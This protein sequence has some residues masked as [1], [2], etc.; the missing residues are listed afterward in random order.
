MT[1]LS[2]L[3]QLGSLW[4]AMALAMGALWLLQRRSGNAGIVDVAWAG[5]LGVAGVF[6]A[7]TSEGEVTRRWL[8]AVLAGVW[9]F[10]LAIYLFFNRYLGRPED[11]RYRALREEWG[12]RA[13]ALLFWFFQLQAS[14]TVLFSLSFLVVTHNDAPA[15]FAWM[16]AAI[17][18]WIISI[19]G[20][21]IAD[22]QLARWRSRPENEGKT[23]RA[24]LWRYSRHP[25]YFF[26]W[27]YWW[28]YVFL[29]LGSGFTWLSVLVAFLMLVFLLK[30]TGIPYTEKCALK[31]REDYAEYQ[32]RTSAFIP[33]FPKEE[34]P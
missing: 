14:W 32:R 8:V 20:E 17:I 33:W 23:C 2:P 13:Q 29:S 26:E 7:A 22:L 12:E 10:R 1:S 11:R 9:S 34:N 16:A 6:Y 24:G 31:S 15:N 18:T 5:G 27:I 25:N 30:V 21:A 28:A 19:G 3:T 4:A